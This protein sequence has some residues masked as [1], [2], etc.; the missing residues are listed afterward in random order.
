MFDG[1]PLLTDAYR[2]RLEY[3]GGSGIVTLTREGD[4]SW[5]AVR[6]ITLPDA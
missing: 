6:D 2:A 3:R 5:L 1:D 4:G